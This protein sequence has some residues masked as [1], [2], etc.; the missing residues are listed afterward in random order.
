MG[1][2][3]GE[4]AEVANSQQIGGNTTTDA[5]KYRKK[6][7][8]RIVTTR[9]EMSNRGLDK[10]ALV[11]KLLLDERVIEL[12]KEN[13]QLSTEL[14]EIKVNCFESRYTASLL[15]IFMGFANENSS[16]S[17][18]TG[19]L[20][21]RC[22]NCPRSGKFVFIPNSKCTFLPFFKELLAMHNL[23]MRWINA[24]EGPHDAQII[25]IS[26]GYLKYGESLNETNPNFIEERK[27][28][29]RLIDYV[30]K[31]HKEGIDE[32]FNE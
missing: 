28:V 6:R 17:L 8:K 27:K 18:G 22:K 29:I 31:V 25:Y 3:T 4:G 20:G 14:E 10:L 7:K 1:V 2:C 13:E 26:S 19:R 12:R 11:S 32:R 9:A 16:K 15:F 23:K 24:D 5:K 21:C 30:K